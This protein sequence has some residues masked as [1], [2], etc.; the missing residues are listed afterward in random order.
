MSAPKRQGRQGRPYY[1]TDCV[2][3]S[4]ECPAADT[5]GNAHTA[6]AR[7]HATEN[8]GHAVHVERLVTLVYESRGGAS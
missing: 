6:W 7:K 5:S 4:T 8:P 2:T 1:R 3:C